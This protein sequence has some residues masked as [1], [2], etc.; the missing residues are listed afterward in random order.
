VATTKGK[1]GIKKS[2]G[3]KKSNRIQ[4]GKAMQQVKSLKGIPYG[5]FVPTYTPQNPS[6]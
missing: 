4:K 2:A 5:G 1:R 3:M 6:G